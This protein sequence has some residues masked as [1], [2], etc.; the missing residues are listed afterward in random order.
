MIQV[1]NLTV[2]YQQKK[3][4]NNFN[5]QVSTGECMLISGPSGCGKSTLA[6]SLTGHIPHTIPAKMTGS[7]R[8]ADLDTQFHSVSHLAQYIGMVFQNPST[9]LF[10]IIVEDEIAFGPRNLGLS[11]IE[12]AE[13]VEWSLKATGLAPLRKSAIDTLSGGQKQH[14]AIAATLAMYPR[15]L[16]L[17]EP[18]ASLD[19]CAVT[20]VLS[21][22]KNLKD[23][24]NVTII[25]FEH[26]IAEVL[27]IVDQMVIMNNGCVVGNGT[28]NSMLSD[29]NFCH[30]YGLRQSF[31]PS[32]ISWQSCIRKKKEYPDKQEVLLELRNISA[33]Y[34]KTSILHNI[35]LTLFAG[36]FTALVGDNGSGKSTLGSVMA[37]L[38]KPSEGEIFFNKEKRLP[39]AGKEVELLFQNPSEQLFMNSVDE[40]VAFLAKNFQCF[41]PDGQNKILENTDL[42]HIRNCQPSAVS[43]GQQQRTALASCLSLQPQLLILDEPS[44]GQDW[45]HLKQLMDFLCHLNRHGTTILIISHDYNLVHQYIKSAILIHQGRIQIKGELSPD[46]K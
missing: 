17:D 40:E 25:I 32:L 21:T 33:G 12:I 7:I 28:P 43:I 23:T 4:L 6:K 11:E 46:P 26:R 18:T 30:R 34:G 19:F 3:V 15:I 41:C 29:K 16:I 45:G 5:L 31:I 9:Q 44:L 8:I 38:I 27:D 36:E 42:T 37:G 20:Q 39:R 10:H 13:R 24:H 14:V 2:Q 1:K 35:N 22:L